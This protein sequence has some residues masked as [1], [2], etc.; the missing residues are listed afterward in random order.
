MSDLSKLK[1]SI[2][3]QTRQKGEARLANAAAQHEA[4]YRE[5]YARLSEN[6]QLER[7]RQLDALNDKYQRESQRLFNQ[8]RQS[9]LSAKQEIL[10]ALFHDALEY[11]NQWS[12]E[13]HLTFLKRVLAKYEGKPVVLTLGE[14]TANTF[15]EDTFHGLHEHFENVK[16]APER[17]V[18]QSGFIITQGQIDDNYLY[19]TLVHAIRQTHNYRIATQIFNEE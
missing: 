7:Q 18:G 17:V 1:T 9:L 3:D 11:L 6:K 2:L 19:A 10:T 13:E 14:L 4:E 15:S 16:I 12:E 8:E 5:R